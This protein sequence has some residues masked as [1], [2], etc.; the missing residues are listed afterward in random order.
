MT[1]IRGLELCVRNQ[2][3]TC[4]IA[5]LTR[6]HTPRLTERGPKGGWEGRRGWVGV[7]SEGDGMEGR[8]RENTKRERERQRQR[9]TDRQTETE[10]QKQRQN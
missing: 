1:S 9:E 8:E 2:G 4:N 3:G 7:G 6:H 5:P 10:R